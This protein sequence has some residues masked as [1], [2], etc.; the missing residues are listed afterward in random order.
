MTE[1]THTEII[2][3]RQGDRLAVPA[4]IADVGDNSPANRR[5]R[6]TENHKAL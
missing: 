1:P 4:I 6:V 2:L 3:R 5:P